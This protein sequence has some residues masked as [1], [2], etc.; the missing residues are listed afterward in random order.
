MKHGL[1]FW[2]LAV[3]AVIFAAIAVVAGFWMF[4]PI[5]IVGILFVILVRTHRSRTNHF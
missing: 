2:S 4:A 5:V 1:F 3:I